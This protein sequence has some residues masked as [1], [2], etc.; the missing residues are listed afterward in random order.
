MCERAHIRLHATSLV[1]GHY[2]THV[3]HVLRPTAVRH[4]HTKTHKD[5]HIRLIKQPKTNNMRTHIQTQ[6]SRQPANKSKTKSTTM[7]PKRNGQW[8]FFF[9]KIVNYY[10]N[11]LQCSY[12]T[13]NNTFEMGKTVRSLCTDSFSFLCTLPFS[14]RMQHF[15]LTFKWMEAI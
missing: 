2:T 4:S 5:T 8:W 11:F 13:C 6:I 7:P 1:Q 3:Q 15:L 14:F 12:R 10:R 9:S